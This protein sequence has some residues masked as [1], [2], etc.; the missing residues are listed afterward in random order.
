MNNQGV[1]YAEL[2]QVKG[3]KRHQMKAKGTKSSIS[4]TEQEI[5][6]AELNLQNASQDLQG[7]DKNSHCKSLPTIYSCP[8]KLIAGILGIIC[9]VLMS[10]VVTIAVIPFYHCGHCPKEWFTYSNNCYYVNTERKSWNESL[11]S[12]AS[13]NSNLLYVDKEDMVRFQMFPVLVIF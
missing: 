8:G 5:T 4:V 13:N 10:T 3:S 2:N 6:Y 11:T 12:C 7:K 1:T 9:L